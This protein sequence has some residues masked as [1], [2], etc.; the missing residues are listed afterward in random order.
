MLKIWNTAKSWVLA[1]KTISI[2]IGIVLLYVA[3][4]R[5]SRRK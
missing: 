2:I 4:V 1:N 3:Y 5:L